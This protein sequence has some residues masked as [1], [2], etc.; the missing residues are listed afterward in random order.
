MSKKIEQIAPS[1]KPV[2]VHEVLHRLSLQADNFSH[3]C[4]MGLLKSDGE[5]PEQPYVVHTKMDQY[6]LIG[7]I[8]DMKLEIL[9]R[10]R[11]DE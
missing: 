11:S 8:E 4:V 5:F 7:L 3:I 6:M 1:D 9:F 10:M 2:G